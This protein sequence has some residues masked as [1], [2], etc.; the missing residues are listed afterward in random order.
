M[1]YFKISIVIEKMRIFLAPILTPLQMLLELYMKQGNTYTGIQWFVYILFYVTGYK[2][3]IFR[4]CISHYLTFEKH[5]HL[6]S[7]YQFYREN[8]L[9]MNEN[10]SNVENEGKWCPKWHIVDYNTTTKYS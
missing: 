6:I 4:P 3:N 10:L 2:K 1:Y 7:F 8:V 5:K 9:Q